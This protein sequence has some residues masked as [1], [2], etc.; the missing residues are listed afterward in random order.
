MSIRV[1]VKL[2]ARLREAVGAGQ[3]ERE[4]SAGTTVG[5]LL[6]DLRA[7]FPALAEAAPRTIVALNRAFAVP[8][9]LIRDGDEVALF[10]PVSGGSDRLRITSTPIS[11]DE[12][13]RSVV[14]PAVGA[15]ASFVGT[16]RDV[17][18]GKAVAYLEYEAYPEMA[19]EMLHQVADEVRARWPD[20]IEIAM[21]QRVGRLEV[22]EIAVVIAISSSHRDQGCFEA[23]RY[24]IDRL[25]QIVPVWKKEFG[26]DG[27]VWIEGDH[28]PGAASFGAG[29]RGGDE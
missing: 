18:E 16:V 12:V 27:A 24:A 3:M 11:A 8:D 1:R 4:V 14:R 13:I 29:R 2:F 10:P 6:A 23:C 20:V 19:V 22:G 7:E 28:L 9:S 21:V 17:S 15:V 5:D 25:K 26:P